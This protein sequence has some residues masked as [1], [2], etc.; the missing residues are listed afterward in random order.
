MLYPESIHHGGIEGVTGSC[1]QL[2]MDA[3][4]SLRIDCGLFQGLETS[5]QGIVGT[6]PSA[7]DFSI[8]TI[9]ALIVTHVHADHVGRIPNLLAAGFKGPILCSE[10]SAKLLPLVLEDAYKLQYGRDEQHVER[11]SK[12]IESRIIALHFGIA[13]SGMCA[14]GRVDNYL[15]AMLGDS[16]YNVP[17]VDYQAKVTPGAAIQQYG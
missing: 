10:P 15:K 1:H 7:I 13:G 11:Y 16:R 9:K 12:L 14:S 2:Q 6:D 3:T 17:L 5:K 8:E 4:S